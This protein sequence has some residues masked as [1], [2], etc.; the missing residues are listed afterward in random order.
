MADQV[1]DVF[2]VVVADGED[3]CGVGSKPGLMVCCIRLS[4]WYT[5][6]FQTRHP[7]TDGRRSKF[8]VG[9]EEAPVD[10]DL[11]EHGAPSPVGV[12]DVLFARRQG[13]NGECEARGEVDGHQV[14]FTACIEGGKN[15]S[16]VDT[17]KNQLAEAF[18]PSRFFDTFAKKV[19]GRRVWI[20]RFGQL[21]TMSMFAHRLGL[22]Q[23]AVANDDI[24]G[25]ILHDVEPSA[26]P[27]VF[28]FEYP[29]EAYFSN[30]WYRLAVPGNQELVCG[31]VDGLYWDGWEEPLDQVFVDH[32]LA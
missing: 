14:R 15:V 25:A 7:P 26:M 30:V 8:M 28:I 23:E 22:S 20:R 2:S 16:A 19:A 10:L 1:L 4:G 17:P 27:Y 6:R 21:E 9:V 29:R 12:P 11:S 32:V 24:L 5:A 3:I 13:Q 31:F 18:V